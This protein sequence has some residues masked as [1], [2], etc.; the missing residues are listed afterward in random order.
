M[1]KLLLLFVAV[2]LCMGVSA[3]MQRIK[4]PAKALKLAVEQ[5]AAIIETNNLLQT[6]NPYV[7]RGS[8]P[9]NEQEIGATV[10]DLQSNVATPSNR[11]E[12]F[13]DGTIGATWTY[14]TGSPNYTDRG[15]AY[16]YFNGSS[17]GPIPTSRLEAAK[18][19]WPAYTKCGPTG[20]CF[21]SH[22]SATV[23][24][25]FLRRD[26]KGTGDWIVST[27][28][29]PEGAP[30]GLLW[31]RLIS[32]GPN[33]EFL[34]LFALTAPSGNGGA[35]Y[36]GQDGAIVYIRST[37]AGLT[38]EEPIVLD[39]MGPDYYINFAGDSY[40]LSATGNNVALTISDNWL[41]LFIMKSTDNGENWEKIVVWEHPIPFWNNVPSIDTIY[42][43][44][45]S[46]HA[47]FDHSGKLHMTFGVNRGLF[48]E[49]DELPSWFPFVDGIAYWNEDKPTWVG[50]DQVNVLNPDLLYEN[51]DLIAF[52][53]D[54][55]GNGELDF[56][57]YE[58]FNIGAYYVSA[59]G[60]PYL[61]IDQ[62]N[63]LYV[64]YASVTE[65]YDNGLQQ[66][67]HLWWVYSL[68]GG[69]TW[70]DPEHLSDNI[71]HMLDECVFPSGAREDGNYREFIP[72]TYQADAEPGL[73]VRGD[74]DQ[75]SDNLIYYTAIQKPNV[76]IDD[77][78]YDSKPIEISVYPN[79]V[80][81]R[82]AKLDIILS[83]KSNVSLELY[84]ITGQ[85]VTETSYGVRQPGV[86]TVMLDI[87]RLNAGVYFVKVKAGEQTKTTKINVL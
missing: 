82:E 32:S 74:E 26:V 20:E 73:S 72:I 54:I 58:T 48:E 83:S 45:G 53:V 11:M 86:S 38:W 2:T 49:G 31:P 14:G 51:G 61:T 21:V 81:S 13:E 12:I 35:V 68:D 17:W 37:D 8:V 23:P 76:G 22:V 70:S 34:H 60:M 64:V 4:A 40:T 46:A 75:P 25:N 27:I 43:P 55:N 39:G 24:L 66:Y 56:I 59:S 5:K 6:V 65:G 62:Y 3:Q 9:Q 19:G 63:G 41:D 67:R 18:A 85:K 69:E 29:A 42:C 44:D 1:R 77:L 80:S 47:V 57:G 15:T 87:S 52:M 7:T 71:L 78:Q 84:S 36:N 10:Y 33:N 30:A 16:N 28:S 50:G 79:P